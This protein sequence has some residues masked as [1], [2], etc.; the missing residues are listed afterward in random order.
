MK[1]KKRVISIV[2]ALVMVLA[3]VMV[4]AVSA[5]AADTKTITISDATHGNYNAYQIFTGKVSGTAPDFVLGDV[6]WGTGVKPASLAAAIAADATIKTYFTIAD[7]SNPKA[8]EIAK[9]LEAIKADT[10]NTDK[11]LRRFAQIAEANKST[12]NTAGSYNSGTKTVTISGLVEGY[13]LVLD[14]YNVADDADDANSAYIIK[15]VE[16]VDMSTKMEVPTLDKKI[17]EK[18]SSSNTVRVTENEASI[19]DKVEYELVTTVPDMTGYTAYYYVMTDTMSKGLTYNDDLV[20]V[21]NDTTPKTLVKDTDYTVNATT[22]AGTGITTIKVVFL[23][24][25]ENYKNARDKEF[26]FTYSGSVNEDAVIGGTTGN[27]NTA[28]LTFS[29]DPSHDYDGEKDEPGSDDPVGKTPDKVTRTFVYGIKLT[30]EDGQTHAVLTGAKF[31]ISA[32]DVTF[33]TKI[34]E[35]LYKESASGTYYKLTDGTYTT[36][37]TFADEKYDDKSKKYEEVTEVTYET[38]K[39]DISKESY[40]KTDG[41]LAFTGL[42]AGSYEI[43]ELVAPEGYNSLTTPISIEIKADYDDPA[44]PTFTYVDQD[45]NEVAVP[46]TGIIEWTVENNQGIVL[47]STGGMG[48]T[49]FYVV[50]GVLVAFAGVLLITKKRMEKQ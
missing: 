34:N 42:G 26:T 22:N 13:Y 8:E 18:D 11:A 37:A 44:N 41:T 21:F 29:N 10:A 6:E 47:P 36:D 23:D 38:V 45:G 16:D 9:G 40:V 35:T 2:L 31:G 43:E 7:T 46:S 24:F 50:G 49:L 14:E 28:A 20:I 19:G 12:T 30:K 3:T 25:L 17:L 15:V 1:T 48:T 39:T 4:P 5:K 32:T 33:I 27:T